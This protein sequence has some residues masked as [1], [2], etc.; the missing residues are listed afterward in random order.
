MIRLTFALGLMIAL[1]YPK[2]SAVARFDPA[3]VWVA[4]GQD[5]PAM[6]GPVTVTHSESS[7]TAAA[8]TL[9]ATGAAMRGALA[10]TFLGGRG[11]L[12]MPSPAGA[13]VTAQWMQPG[14]AIDSNPYATPVVLRA[15]GANA[16]TGAVVPFV[17]RYELYVA[18]V[19]NADGSLG[20]FMRDPIGD[21]G[22]MAPFETVAIDGDNIT[23]TTRAHVFHGSVNATPSV[24]VLSI[25]TGP[26]LRFH[27][28]DSNAPNGY[29]PIDPGEDPSFTRPN[30]EDDGW[31]I[32][33]PSSVGMDDERVQ[34]FARYLASQTPTSPGTPYIQSVLI[35]R[36]D[37][38]VT[39]HYYYGFSRTR[40]HDVRSAGKSLDAA[41]FGAAM[42]I[43]PRLTVDTAA[44]RW[45]P[46]SD[47]AHPD[48]RKLQ[49]SVSDFFDMTSGLDCDDDN[50][51]SPGNEDAMQSQ[52][53]QP[54]WYRY[55]MDLPMVSDPGS[56]KAIY[57]SGGMNMVGAFII[58]ATHS[59][60]P[61]LFADALARP[62]QFG[63]Y[64][65]QLTPTA[66]MYLGGGSYFLPR[67]FLKLGQ[68][69]LDDGVWNGRRVLAQAWVRDAVSPHSGLN[70]PNDYGYG[71]HLT[72]YRTSSAT[73]TAFE[74]QGN[75]GQLLIVVPRLRLV[76]GIMAAN[77]GDYRT[78]GTF[79]DL[80]ERYIVAAC[81]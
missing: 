53:T 3:G 18:F 64:H 70:A 15:S 80:V 28:L 14:S 42:R 27:R 7:W 72:Q 33:T 61:E 74:A 13:A 36:Y 66:E 38:L 9:R 65:L 56:R 58:G 8:G 29:F 2:A 69:F 45:L 35:A 78:W 63:I 50:D 11:Q 30:A 59:W 40:P 44:Y 49:I 23:I 54:D 43:A 32:G 67:D 16:W 41:L 71:W 20:G 17:P 62:L 12:R 75:G 48:T 34:K 39:E 1:L 73:Y 79:H 68:V 26:P 55:V 6:S 57:C 52:T 4:S 77:Y 24:L 37:R 51:A 19:R 25:G 22:T 81:R 31:K 10:F 46:Y 47:F 21:F 76:V 60:T 5:Q